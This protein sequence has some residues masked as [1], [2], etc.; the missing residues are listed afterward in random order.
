MTT[1]CNIWMICL[2]LNWFFYGLSRMFQFSEF[3][4]ALSYSVWDVFNNFLLIDATDRSKIISDQRR[5]FYRIKPIPPFHFSRTLPLNV[6]KFWKFNSI[7][8]MEIIQPLIK[9]L[10]LIIKLWINENHL[11]LDIFQ[12]SIVVEFEILVRPKSGKI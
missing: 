11:K 2:K 8:K 6:K 12:W 9:L 7:L 5:F 1:G 4:W 10:M 3:V